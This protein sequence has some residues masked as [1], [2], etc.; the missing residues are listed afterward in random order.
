EPLFRVVVEIDDV[1][2]ELSDLPAARGR[3]RFL[4]V[5]NRIE[6]QPSADAVASGT[7]AAERGDRE[8]ALDHFRRAAAADPFNPWPSYHASMVLLELRRYGEAVESYRRTEAL[9][10]G[11]YHCRG[12]RWLAERLAAGD[13]D[14]AV[15]QAV[16]QL[17]DGRM[18]P[19][20]A[21]ALDE[22][23][24]ARCELGEVR[25]ALGEALV[26]LGRKARP[27]RPIAGRWP[28]P[29]SPMFGR[30]CWSHWATPWPIARSAGNC[31]TGRSSCRATWCR[32]R[33]RRSCWGP[34]PTRIDLMID[35]RCSPTNK[36]ASL[37][38]QYA[39]APQ[40]SEGVDLAL[41]I[42]E[43]D[44]RIVDAYYDE[45]ALEASQDRSPP[46]PEEQVELEKLAVSSERLK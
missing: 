10:P 22:A 36:R 26:K 21:V 7:A 42:S 3:V 37:R 16:R 44:I 12:D 1:T 8:A 20:H 34:C 32:R 19:D 30:G 15:F 11:W 17:L 43:G 6:L 33:W 18:A 27:R 2:W 13:V 40:A 24:L 29:T 5:S 25:L 45:L 39:S 38:T 4:F 31:C 46:T 9:A 14:H 23:T 28:A 35:D 41:R